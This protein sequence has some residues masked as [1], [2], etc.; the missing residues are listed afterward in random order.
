M[1]QHHR[2]WIE[3]IVSS[4]E[5]PRNFVC[6]RKKSRPLCTTRDVEID[7]HVAVEGNN[8]WCKF[9]THFAGG[10]FCRCPLCVYLTKN[11]LMGQ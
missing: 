7:G 8:R 4:I 3:Q 5:C 11:N 9:K 1:E 2:D 6:Y 10:D